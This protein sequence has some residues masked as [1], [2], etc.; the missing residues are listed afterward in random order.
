MKVFLI[1]FF[2]L[3]LSCGAEE[4]SEV[5]SDQVN[6]NLIGDWIYEYTQYSGSAIGFKADKNCYEAVMV[7][8]S[9]TTVN[10]QV[11]YCTF[12]ITGDRIDFTWKRSSL[13]YHVKSSD[14]GFSVDG[15]KFTI[16]SSA[17]VRS[18]ERVPENPA[19]DST[20]TII[21]GYFDLNDEFVRHDI[22]DL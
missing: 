20:I 9:Y 21:F 15:D 12:E 11:A 17:A 14:R 2:S 6:S 18:Y 4:D 1:L 22:I 16:Y 8:T 7:F 5:S 13:P 3:F 19:D 10:A